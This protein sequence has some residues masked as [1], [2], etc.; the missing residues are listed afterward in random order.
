LNRAARCASANLESASVISRALAIR[1]SINHAD[2][3][4]NGVFF[5]TLQFPKLRYGK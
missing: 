4:V 1:R 3:H 2:H 5:E